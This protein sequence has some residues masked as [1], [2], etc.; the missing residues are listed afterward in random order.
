VSER[1]KKDAQVVDF[2]TPAPGVVLLDTTALSF[3]E[4]VQ[5]LLSL[6]TK[7]G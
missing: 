7:T 5:K 1:D 3:E 2:L 6:I 4:S